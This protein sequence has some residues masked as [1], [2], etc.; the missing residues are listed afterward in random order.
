MAVSPVGADDALIADGTVRA[1]PTTCQPITD[2]WQ[3]G[4]PEYT[5]TAFLDRSVLEADSTVT[6]T[7]DLHLAAYPG[8]TA[9]A[10]M[11]ALTHAASTCTSFTQPDTEGQIHQAITPLSTN[12]GDQSVAWYS[13]MTNGGQTIYATVTVVRVGSSVITALELSDAVKSADQLPPTNSALISAQI[14]KLRSHTS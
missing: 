9:K 1:Q 8:T 7:H 3:G 6:A 12:L 13:A 10:F 14:N 4:A 5:A 11:D 2:A